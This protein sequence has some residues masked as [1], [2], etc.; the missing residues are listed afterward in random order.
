MIKQG[1]KRKGKGLEKK[2]MEFNKK[3]N[4]PESGMKN[5][6]MKILNAVCA[7]CESFG[8]C[9]LASIL[10]V[11]VW[12]GVQLFAKGTIQ[13]DILTFQQTFT[14]ARM[15]GILLPLLKKVPGIMDHLTLYNI[16]YEVACVLFV[17]IPMDKTTIFVILGIS[18]CYPI[19]RW[20]LEFLRAVV[21]D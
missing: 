15:V 7:I 8:D 12:L 14:I 20:S 19:I 18:C 17:L 3:K 16:T 6:W 13:M 9:F 10:I 4:V 2:M 11:S 1:S 5:R 21:G